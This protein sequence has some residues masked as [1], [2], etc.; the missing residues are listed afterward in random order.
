MF[1]KTVFL[2][3]LL[4]VLFFAQFFF[5]NIKLVNNSKDYL[6]LMDFVTTVILSFWV[7][8]DQQHQVYIEVS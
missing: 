7:R 2:R 4:Y 1:K 3:F 5:S 6:S 8:E